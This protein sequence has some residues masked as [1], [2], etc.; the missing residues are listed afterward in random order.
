MQ[1]KASSRSGS[2]QLF[3]AAALFTLL[4]ALG[5]LVSLILGV[6]LDGT[7]RLG[8]PFLTGYPSRF[9]EKA[10]LLPALAG[11]VGLIIIAGVVALPIGI[12][13]AIYFEE[14]SKQTWITRILEINIANLAAVPSI[15]YGLLGLQL[16]VRAL[17]LGRSLIAG[18]L[19]LA[20]LILPVII[21]A[22]RQALRTV[23]RSLRDASLA[24]GATRW[25]TVWH[26]V[27]PGAFPGILTGAI[28]ALSRALGE[29][30]PLVTLGAL[31]Y[32]AFIPKG[33]TSPFTALP[34]Q[35]FNWI[36][37]PQEAFHANAA[38]AILVLLIIL[39]VVN[40]GAIYLRGRLQRKLN[41]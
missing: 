25:Q 38:A 41:W 39:I 5:V 29:T 2:E 24:L 36:S 1:G 15:I 30:A 13:A 12:G 17:D 11:S 10:G 19:T 32:V 6:I 21:I 7:E 14:Y 27:L 26:H 18:G 35:V 22:S 4:L 31:T 16:F 20:L 23:P 3:C 33:L 8:I 28:L 40:A 9:A 37:R 34:I